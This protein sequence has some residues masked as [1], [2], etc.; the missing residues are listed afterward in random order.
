M[1]TEARPRVLLAD[2]YPGV[3]DALER[4]LAPDCDVVGAIRDGT[5]VCEASRRL[6]PDVIVLDLNMAGVNG[7][8]VCQQIA[9]TDRRVRVILLSAD[10][11]AA[12]QERALSLGALA[13]ISKDE[14]TDRLLPIIMEARRH[15][16]R[17]EPA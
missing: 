9:Q 8:D 14:V 4:L 13:V 7:L 1:S 15:F 5:A 6:Q 11:R 10:M 16:T 12:I 3:L 2:D 17:M